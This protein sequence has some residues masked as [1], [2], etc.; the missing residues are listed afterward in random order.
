MQE[1]EPRI[2]VSV[3]VNR[4]LDPQFVW[5]VLCKLM[6]LLKVVARLVIDRL[7]EVCIQLDGELVLFEQLVEKRKLLFI[8]GIFTIVELDDRC[9]GSTEE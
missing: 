6:D 5:Q 1:K 4:K 8:L 3:K 2:E 9:K 7:L